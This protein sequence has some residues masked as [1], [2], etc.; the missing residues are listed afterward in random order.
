MSWLTSRTA[1]SAAH[2]PT[3]S[4]GR[5]FKRNLTT[6]LAVLPPRVQDSPSD[7]GHLEGN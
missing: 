3:N 6:A 4:P 7:R 2:W 1:R 5:S